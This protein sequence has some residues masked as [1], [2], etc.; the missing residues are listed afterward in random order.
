MSAAHLSPEHDFTYKVIE[1]DGFEIKDRIEILLSSDTEMGTAKSLGLGVLGYA[2]C[3]F[4]AKPDVVLVLGDRFEALAIAQVALIFKIPIIHIHGGEITAGAYDDSIRHAIT[5]FSSLHFVTSESHKQRVIQLGE[6]PNRVFNIGAPGLEYIRRG[7]L[8]SRD[9]LEKDLLFQLDKPFVLVTFHPETLSGVSSE[10]QFKELL[11][12]LDCF[13]EIKVIFTHP[14]ADEGGRAISKLI[15]KYTIDNSHRAFA[16]VSLGQIRYLS[17]MK[18]AEAVIGNS[19]SGI[20]EAAPL[21]TPTINIGDRQKGRER[22]GSVIDCGIDS[23]VIKE[24]IA[25]VLSDPFDIS[26]FKSPY[27]D[28][29]VAQKVCALIRTNDLNVKKIFYDL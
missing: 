10:N 19:S 6:P 20:I 12:A 29:D 5:K 22:A 26:D 24:E 23:D 13:P 11:R 16:A 8:L 15:E 2:E 14:N 3:L 7:Q 9:E 28:G 18:Y 1:S 17:A 27:G 21:M 25:R 4:K